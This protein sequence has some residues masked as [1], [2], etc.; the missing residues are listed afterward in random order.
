[1]SNIFSGRDHEVVNE[2]AEPDQ[3]WN[4]IGGQ[5]TYSKCSGTDFKVF[6]RKF[7]V[8]TPTPTVGHYYKI[9]QKLIFKN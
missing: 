8:P 1:M 3:F 4:S 7:S 2:K 6:L 5:G 9:M